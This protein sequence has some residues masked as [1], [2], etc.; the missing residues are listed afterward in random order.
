MKDVFDRIWAVWDEFWFRPANPL[1]LAFMRISLGLLM[2]CTI[3]FSGPNWNRFYGR[4]GMLSLDVPQV[5]AVAG[6]ESPWSVFYWG[7]GV[8]PIYTWWVLGVVAAFCFT[9]GFQTRIATIALYILQCSMIH[10]HRLLTNGDDLMFRLLLFYSLFARLGDRVSVDRWLASRKGQAPSEED[11]QSWPWVWPQRML[12]IC[13][14]LVYAISLPYKFSQD[15]AWPLGQALYWTMA[16]D[17]WYKGYIPELA[18][19]WGPWFV[20]AATYGTVVIEGAF[21]VLV[22]FPSLRLWAVWLLTA[23]HIGIAIIIPNVFYFTMSMVASFW[24]FYPPEMLQSWI[25][26]LMTRFAKRGPGAGAKAE[27]AG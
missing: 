21:P 20:Y 15:A 4:D 19:K 16:S 13:V 27:M 9:V 22:W 24:I 1:P 26:Y 7:D 17:M 14:V 10:R 6:P 8:V 18:Y 23:L 25:D 2:C 12:Q 3:T 5:A 11:P